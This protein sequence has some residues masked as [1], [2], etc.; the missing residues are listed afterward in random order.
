MY[1]VSELSIAIE[2]VG[3]INLVVDL[4]AA[5]GNDDDDDNEAAVPP[6]CL[7]VDR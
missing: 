1:A 2:D 4:V 5:A 6:W 7:S 3:T